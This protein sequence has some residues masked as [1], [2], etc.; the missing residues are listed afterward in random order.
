MILL[1]FPEHAVDVEVI[2]LQEKV[3]SHEV[4][5]FIVVVL[6][7]DMEQLLMVCRHNGKAVFCQ[8]LAEQRVEIFQLCGVHQ[9]AH[10]HPETF[11][12][13]EVLLHQLCLAFFHSLHEGQLLF[14]IV[15]KVSLVNDSVIEVTPFLAFLALYLGALHSLVESPHQRVIPAG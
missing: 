14:G 7:I 15:Q 13:L 6:L 10:V 1:K 9:V 11:L 5:E 4:R 12:N 2:N 8:P 3:G